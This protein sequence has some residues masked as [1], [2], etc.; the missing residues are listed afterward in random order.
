MKFGLCLQVT[1]A[2]RIAKQMRPDM[3]IEGP[4]QVPIPLF[5][6]PEFRM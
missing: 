2:V 4:I 3:M 6:L 1:D 5:V